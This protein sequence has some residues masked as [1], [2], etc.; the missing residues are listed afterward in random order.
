MTGPVGNTGNF[1]EDYF[2]HPLVSQTGYNPVN[3]A[4]YAIIAI[5]ALYFIWDIFKRKKIV[6]DKKFVYAVLPFILLGSTMRVVT[7]SIDN[8]KFKAITPIHEAIINSHIYDYG[9]LT[10]TPGVYLVT[11]AILFIS[12]GVLHLIKKSQ[13]LGH[14]GLILWLFH[15]LLL[16]PFMQYIMDAIPI[17]ILA[18]IPTIIAWK[19][20][21]NEIY[22]LIVAGHAL[23]GAATFYVIDVFGPKIGKLYFE[24]HVVGG[25]IG[26]VF[27][28]FFAFYLVKLA[29]SFGVA[30]LLKKEK[31]DENFKNFIALAIMIMGFA[32]GIRDVLRMVVGA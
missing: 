27:G 29:I 24:Q 21:K 16:V 23:D 20:L 19:Y 1:I 9:Y 4:V 2:I 12:M 14:V 30:H 6:I 13:Y 11:A 31:E 25:F 15:F 32:P 22:A 18:L 28:T 26:A 10:V 8:N 7:D 3:T 17:L 5:I